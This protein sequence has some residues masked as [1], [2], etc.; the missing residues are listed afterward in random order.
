MLNICCGTHLHLERAIFFIFCNDFN[1]CFIFFRWGNSRLFHITHAQVSITYQYLNSRHLS[2]LLQ[3]VD[4]LAYE[5]ICLRRRSLTFEIDVKMRRQSKLTSRDT[6]CLMYSC[7]CTRIAAYT[8]GSKVS[9]RDWEYNVGE[10]NEWE[11]IIERI[12]LV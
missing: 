2:F 3:L 5:A 12:F 9:R 11:H 1:R 7:L 10:R 8:R 6:S 4:N